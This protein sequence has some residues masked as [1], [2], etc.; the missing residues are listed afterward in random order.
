MIHK[1]SDYILVGIHDYDQT[2][3]IDFWHCPIQRVQAEAASLCAESQ[4]PVVRYS[5]RDEIAVQLESEISM[6]TPLHSNT[7]RLKLT[8]L[9]CSSLSIFD[10]PMSFGNCI[11]SFSFS[12]LSFCSNS[13]KLT[14]LNKGKSNHE[15]ST[16]PRRYRPTYFPIF[17]EGLLF[18]QNFRWR[19]HR[20]I[21]TI[22]NTVRTTDLCVLFHQL[23]SS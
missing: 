17:H 1:Q 16:V 2:W 21:S 18:A 5:S 12:T 3:T 19:R 9:K 4:N 10:W 14:I 6:I 8:I 23:K 22:Q 15:P 20:Y 7:F 11:I 13:Y